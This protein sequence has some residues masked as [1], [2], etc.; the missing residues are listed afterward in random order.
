MPTQVNIFCILKGK[1]LMPC[2]RYALDS[3]SMY[4][5]KFLTQNKPD[6]IF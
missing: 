4:A 6:N 5:T 1:E 2:H 3:I